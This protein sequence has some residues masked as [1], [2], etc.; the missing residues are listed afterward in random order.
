MCREGLSPRPPPRSPAVVVV[1]APPAFSSHVVWR[2]CVRASGPSLGGIAPDARAKAPAAA[3]VLAVAPAAEARARH[4]V[5]GPPTG[6]AA[7]RS[8]KKRLSAAVHATT[9]LALDAGVVAAAVGKKR[10]ASVRPE[11]MLGSA[12]TLVGTG[13]APPSSTTNAGGVMVVDAAGARRA[14]AG[15][16][17]T[18][19]MRG[20][21]SERDPNVLSE[22]LQVEFDDVFAE[23]EGTYSLDSVWK[24]ATLTFTHTKNVCYRA[25]SLLCAVPLALIVGISFACLSFQHIWCIGPAIR[26]CRVNCHVVRQYMRIILES[27]CAPCFSEMGLVLS[28]IRVLH[29][30]NG[31]RHHMESI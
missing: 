24:A 13:P 27:C 2:E 22:Y 8:T 12:A 30:Q 28:R 7:A 6:A 23:P 16:P 11:V 3:A 9:T 14:G 4:S 18:T 15:A 19:M 26:H 31:D 10:T 25:L 29:L 20:G 17:S 1:S 21:G 5:S